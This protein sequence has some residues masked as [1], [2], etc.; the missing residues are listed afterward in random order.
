M[1]PPLTLKYLKEFTDDTGLLQHAK[2]F[3]PDRKEG[4]ST[5]D[6]ARALVVVAKYYDLRP[7]EIAKRLARTYLSFLCYMHRDDGLFYNKLSY[8]RQHRWDVSEDCYGR[9]IWGCASL[10]ASKMPEKLKLAAKELLETSLKPIDSLK[11]PRGMAMTIIGLY[12][13]YQITHDSRIAEYIERLAWRL[14]ELYD[15]VAD[16]SWRWFEDIVAYENA[17]LPQALFLAYDVT[18]ELRFLEVARESFEFLSKITIVDGIF[19]PIGNRGWYR[20]GGPRALYD[21]QPVE[22]GAMVETALSGFKVAKDERYLKIARIAMEWYLGRNSIRRSIY[23]KESGGCYDGI[24]PNGLNYN[25]GAEAALSFLLARLEY[26]RLK[27]KLHT[28]RAILR[29]F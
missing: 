18:K 29:T 2:Y 7:S 6:N 27:L 5:D 3:V 21:Q 14:V 26:E 19:W 25:Q 28:P 1:L 13:Y 20:R 17:R 4:Y 16:S 22:A 10:F 9:A 11:S 15:S 8:D 12:E 23:D 24:T